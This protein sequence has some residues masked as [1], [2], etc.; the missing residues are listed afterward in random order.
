[1][2]EIWSFVLIDGNPPKCWSD[3]QH[4]W[5]VIESLEKIRF[6]FIQV[7]FLQTPCT[8]KYI[9]ELSYHL[10]TL[11]KNPSYHS[12]I[13]RWFLFKTWASIVYSI[14]RIFLSFFPEVSNCLE[15]F[16][17]TVSVRIAQ[18]LMRNHLIKR[19]CSVQNSN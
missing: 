11:S 16:K 13:I 7:I 17:S 18:P 1:M 14:F 3:K 6:P 12:H 5:K 10:I 19:P 2:A 9:I 4:G 8:C 15:E